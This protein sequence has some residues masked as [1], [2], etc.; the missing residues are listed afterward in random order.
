[1]RRISI[2]VA[3]EGSFSYNLKKICDWRDV[4]PSKCEQDNSSFD[5]NANFE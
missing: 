1:M 3:I 4:E 5:K 2:I